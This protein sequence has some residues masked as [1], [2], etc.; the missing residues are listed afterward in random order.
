MPL[1]GGEQL[2][3]WLDG[4]LGGVAAIAAFFGIQRI[5][6]LLGRDGS[7]ESPRSRNLEM[8]HLVHQIEELRGMLTTFSTSYHTEHD[9]TRATE[10]AGFAEMREHHSLQRIVEM[11]QA[12]HER[13]RVMAAD[14][15]RRTA[16]MTQGEHERT[17]EV[18]AD[19]I[20]EVRRTWASER[21]LH[22]D[23]ANQLTVSL[24]RQ[25]AISKTLEA[26]LAELRRISPG[27]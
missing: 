6:I 15:L 11:A 14:I 4:I 9:R 21:Q 16:E 13:T 2:P 3:T 7:E 20:E 10:N 22:G 1:D 18:A 24:E 19:M 8:D 12:E 5:R 25:T 23:M 26:I 17:R 27:S